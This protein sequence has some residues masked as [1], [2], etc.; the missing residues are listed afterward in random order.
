MA[1]VVCGRG[2]KGGGKSGDG[3]TIWEALAVCNSDEGIFRV[4]Q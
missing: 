1:A 2:K 3:K 4:K